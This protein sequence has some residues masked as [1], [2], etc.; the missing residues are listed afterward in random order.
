VGLPQQLA[1]IQEQLKSINKYI[2]EVRAILEID[3]EK[4]SQMVLE[5]ALRYIEKSSSFMAQYE[6]KA[7][8][9]NGS[10]S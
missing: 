10:T 7:K 5:L 9:K 4:S 6:K 8:P 1:Q 2:K 3:C